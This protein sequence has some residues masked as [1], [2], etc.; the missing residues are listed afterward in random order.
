MSVDSELRSAEV[1]LGIDLTRLREWWRSPI[2]D[3]CS[4]DSLCEGQRA[5]RLVTQGLQQ[6]ILLRNHRFAGKIVIEQLRFAARLP[7][8]PDAT[9]TF[10]LP[11]W[12]IFLQQAAKTVL[13]WTA[14]CDEV[15]A[16]L[17]A[18]FVKQAWNCGAVHI[19][20][21]FPKAAL[22]IW[23]RLADEDRKSVV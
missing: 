11:F 12:M 2:Q 22:E 17:R 18:E 16:E 3:G 1:L 23:R 19:A 6:T 13:H 10:A 20:A 21:G 7:D 8:E 4:L 5:A 9:P 15:P 14:I